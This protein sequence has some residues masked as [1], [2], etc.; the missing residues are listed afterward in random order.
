MSLNEKERRGQEDLA[1]KLEELKEGGVGSVAAEAEPQ[2]VPKR[3]SGGIEST[4][5]EIRKNAEQNLERDKRRESSGPSP[6][7]TAVNLAEEVSLPKPHLT[8]PEVASQI[9]A[10]MAELDDGAK[11]NAFRK[12]LAGALEGEYSQYAVLLFGHFAQ[13]TVLDRK[14]REVVK[15]K[16]G[17]DKTRNQAP[18][19]RRLM[20]VIDAIIAEMPENSEDRVLNDKYGEVM[21]SLRDEESGVVDQDKL[22]AAIQAAS[23][24]GEPF[25]TDSRRFISNGQVEG[26]ALT[27]A[28]LVK[29]GV[30]SVQET[31]GGGTKAFVAGGRHLSEAIEKLA[32][33]SKTAAELLRSRTQKTP[34]GNRSNKKVG[35]GLSGLAELSA[36]AGKPKAQAEDK[37]EKVAEAPAESDTQAEEAAEASEEVSSETDES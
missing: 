22:V 12:V 2:A 17:S 15:N 11:V 5:R 6:F 1:A 9:E 32:E 30:I 4:R 33:T 37:S 23:K 14:T 28:D 20:H 24:A 29:A 21:N 10:A 8:Q 13:T 16:D 31:K 25:W 35:S 18:E 34:G 26:S 3:T 19:A 36:Q 7:W 27:L